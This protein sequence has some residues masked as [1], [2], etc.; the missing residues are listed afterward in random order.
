[1][2]PKKTS[3]AV[4]VA[5]DVEAFLESGAGTKTVLKFATGAVIFKQGDVSQHVFYVQGGGVKLS[6]VS[7]TG[8]EAVV[9]LLG[10][11]DFFGEGCLAGQRIRMGSATAITPSAVLLIGK[12]QMVR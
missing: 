3:R 1:M 5:F 7:K 12:D 9:A 8:R 10:Q 4:A 6:V 11:G 2:A